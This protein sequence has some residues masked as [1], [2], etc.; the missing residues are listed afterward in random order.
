MSESTS[1]GSDYDGLQLFQPQYVDKACNF[2]YTVQCTKRLPSDIAELTE[3]GFNL[4][5]FQPTHEDYQ[6]P[7]NVGYMDLSFGKEK[8]ASNLKGAFKPHLQLKDYEASFEGISESQRKWG[9]ELIDWDWTEQHEGRLETESEDH[10]LALS[11]ELDDNGHPFLMFF[12]H[13]DYDHGI[14]NIMT[15]IGKKQK[16]KESKAVGLSKSEMDRLGIWMSDR[17]VKQRKEEKHQ[18]S[19]S[20]KEEQDDIKHKND[21]IGS[22]KRRGQSPVVA[23]S[24]KKIKTE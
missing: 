2:I 7:D 12:L 10:L 3:V 5:W 14:E 20:I 19:Q 22:I 1:Q 8:I 15:F 4:N 9:W 17:E 16:S 6:R 23:G 13:F 11:E 18:D 24:S 21:S